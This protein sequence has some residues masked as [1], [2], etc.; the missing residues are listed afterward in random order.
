M[1]SIEWAKPVAMDVY[2]DFQKCIFVIITNQ[3][4][5][6]AENHDE[7]SKNQIYIRS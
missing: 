7:I 4:E 1:M 5:M 3:L 2:R 6:W